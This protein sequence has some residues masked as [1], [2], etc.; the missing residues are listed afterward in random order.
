MR[1]KAI[2]LGMRLN[3][4]GLFKVGSDGSVAP[5]PEPANSEADLFRLLHMNY[6]TPRE[7]DI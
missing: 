7:R 1:N 3:E 6:K 2:E 4:Y 5:R